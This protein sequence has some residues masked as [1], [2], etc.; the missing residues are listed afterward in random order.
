[1]VTFT[2]QEAKTVKAGL[3]FIVERAVFN[4]MTI[5]EMDKFLRS[6]Q[7]IK[8]VPEAVKALILEEPSIVKTD[9]EETEA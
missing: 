8:K 7:Q 5:P 1:M 6:M 2:E 4:R 3:E 9:L